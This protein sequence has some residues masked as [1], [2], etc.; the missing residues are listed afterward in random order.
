MSKLTNNTEQL[1]SLLAKINA[2]PEAGGG[3]TD[4]SDAT[5]SADKIFAGETA[6][7]ADGK[8]TGTFTI[9]TELSTQ[10]NLISQLS[11]ILDSKACGG[12]SGYDTC[13]VTVTCFK[14]LRSYCYTA[15]IDGVLTAMFPSMDYNDFPLVLENVLCGSA[16]LLDT[17]YGLNG[18]TV[19]DNITVNRIHAYSCIF[20]AP[21]NDG[22]TGT[23]DIYDAD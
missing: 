11:T 7:I 13:T 14:T 4:T 23:I 12:S 8:V 3:G 1:E 2:L 10:E 18:A 21:I 17:N 19:S 20:T 16:I 6:Y 5:A 22:A 15:V 9:D